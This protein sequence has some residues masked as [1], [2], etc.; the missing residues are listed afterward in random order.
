M[1]S[2]LLLRA[3]DRLFRSLVKL[4]PQDFRDELGESVV[5]TYRDRAR[6]ALKEGGVIRLSGVWMSAL[7]DSIVSGPTEHHRPAAWWRRGGNWGR[8]IE[9]ARRRLMRSPAMVLAVV[10]TL[11]VG[12]GA[13]A[14]VY[15]G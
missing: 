14:V 9:V 8:D 12:L 7:K 1:S 15:T 11:T 5:E 13:F 6:R 2:D 4:Y 10:G 3:S